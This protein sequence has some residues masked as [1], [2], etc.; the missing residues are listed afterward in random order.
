M[1]TITNLN[2]AS[3]ATARSLWIRTHS[4]HLECELLLDDRLV[5]LPDRSQ[6]ALKGWSK[7]PKYS[8]EERSTKCSPSLVEHVESQCSQAEAKCARKR[9]KS[10]NPASKPSWPNLNELPLFMHQYFE[11]VIKVLGD[12]HCGFRVVSG[13]IGDSVDSYN[14]VRLDLSVE[15][16]NKKERY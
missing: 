6:G 9:S 16:K 14:L 7:R 12:G 13:L 4:R 5:H 8:Q 15:L 10:P 3:K 2:N 1:Q 11:N